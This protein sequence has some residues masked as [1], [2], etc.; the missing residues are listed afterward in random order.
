MTTTLTKSPN[1][2]ERIL[3][4]KKVRKDHALIFPVNC[5]QHWFFLKVDNYRIYVYDSLSKEKEEAYES[6]NIILNVKSFTKWYYGTEYLVEL[7]DDFPQ[8]KNGYDC[9]VFMLFGIKDTVREN[10]WS[11]QQR[12]IRYKRVLLCKELIEETISGFGQ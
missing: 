4:K 5:S 10:P 12:D 6:N 2:I 1:V 7:C 9:G 3:E 11:F 8:Q